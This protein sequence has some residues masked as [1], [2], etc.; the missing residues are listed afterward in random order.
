M[1]RIMDHFVSWISGPN[2]KKSNTDPLQWNNVQ[3][4]GFNLQGLK[5]DTERSYAAK[6]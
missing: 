4:K 1:C 5:V 6:F 3:S 2:K